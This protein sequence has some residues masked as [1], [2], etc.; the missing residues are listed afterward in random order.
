MLPACVMLNSSQKT[1]GIPN[2]Y[3]SA[4]A[5]LNLSYTWKL[6]NNVHNAVLHVL[7]MFN[8]D[9]FFSR[10]DFAPELWK[11]LFLPHMS[12]VVGW[13]SEERHRLVMDVIPD[14]SDL[15]ITVDFDQFFN[16]SL[17]FSM[18]PDQTE[19]LQ[20]LEQV[21]GQ[22]LDENTRLYAKYYKD[23]MNF[24]SAT[25]KK[26][27]PMLPI[28]EAPMTPLHEVSRS[29]PD[30]VKFGPILPKSAG[31]C[32]VLKSRDNGRE[33]SRSVSS[34]NIMENYQYYS[35]LFSLV[36]CCFVIVLEISVIEGSEIC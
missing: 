13:Y 27:I 17:V 25:S 1:S 34:P 22:S 35:S 11:T 8:V 29:I 4:W 15:S 18:R 12:S 2:F 36:L 19:K 23:C 10:I 31:F 20:K 14:S 33:A 5:H 32:P 30:Y 16:E 3:L 9:P 26:V 21:Y 7:E 28:V 24:D 6:R